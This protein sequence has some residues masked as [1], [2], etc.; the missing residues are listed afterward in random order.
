M[1][2]KFIS[3]LLAFL[4]IFTGTLIA[5]DDVSYKMPPKEIADMLLVKPTPGVSIDDNGEWVLFMQGSNYPAV[6]ELA[7]PEYRI[8][9][10]RMNPANFAP[11]R[12]NFITGLTL[13]NIASGKTYNISGLPAPLYA[14]AVSWSPDN[15]KIAFTNTQPDRVDL[16]VITV[17]TQKSAKINTT[18]LN[19]ITGG[20]SWFDNNSLLYRGIVA[21]A[22]A[23]PKKPLTPKGPAVQENYGKASPRPTF[24][25]MIKSPFDEA[26]FAFFATTQLIKNTNGVESKIG[27]PAIYQS[28]SASPDKKYLLQETTRKPF[29]YLVPSRSF[30]SVVSIT[31]LYGKDLNWLLSCHLAKL[32]RVVTIMFNLSL[33][34][35]NGGMMPR[36]HSFGPSL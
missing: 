26:L 11:S 28:V 36:P 1:K 15:K 3:S 33:V 32:H 19:T 13:K 22:S 25:D 12:Q 27:Q 24:Q 18:A 21:P 20:Y 9:G 31:D 17:A 4:L 35:L 29:S 10:L 34:V 16:Y 6:E 5:Q 8:A 30:A 7:R 14:G 23:A 2:K